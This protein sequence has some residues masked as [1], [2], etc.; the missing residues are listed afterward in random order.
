MEILI[1]YALEIVSALAVMLIGVA[2]TYLTAK[3]AKRAEL[4]NIAQ[5]MEQVTKAAQTAVGELQQTLAANWKQ[6]G[7]GRLNEAQINELGRMLQLR[8][9]EILSP[10]VTGLL[11]AAKVD[12][13][14]LITAAGEDWIRQIK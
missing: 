6:A 5:A 12:V 14:A 13:T 3:A 7:G 11:E 8:A 1:E 9:R 2:G 4:D 10:S